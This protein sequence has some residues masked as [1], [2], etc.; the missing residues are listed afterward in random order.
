MEATGDVLRQLVPVLAVLFTVVYAWPQVVRALRHGV[1]GVAVGAIALS[2]LASSA[3]LGYGIAHRL[4]PV[5]ISN[6]GVLAG[7]LVVLTLL[8]RHR[9]VE[10]WKAVLCAV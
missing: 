2:V 7:Q 5:V 10:P 8:A 4:P 3:W 6:L 9:A 1:E